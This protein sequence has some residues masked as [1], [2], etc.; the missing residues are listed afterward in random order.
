MNTTG[1]V[2]IGLAALVVGAVVLLSAGRIQA[3]AINLLG[4][5]HI[6]E[7][8]DLPW[9]GASVRAVL[10]ARRE[11]TFNNGLTARRE[12]GTGRWRTEPLHQTVATAVDFLARSP[13]F[14]T[15]PVS[16]EEAEFYEGNAAGV[17]AGVYPVRVAPYQFHL[18]SIRPTVV[19][20]RADSAIV[21]MAQSHARQPEAQSEF[22]RW[23]QEL[24]Y[25]QYLSAWQLRNPIHFGTQL[26]AGDAWQWFSPDLQQ[27]PTPLL[28]D[29]RAI[30]TIPLPDGVLTFDVTE[31]GYTVQRR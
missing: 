25:L 28:L 1:I 17:P 26:P 7:E 12:W 14:T 16:G 22:S 5:T 29:D 19:L 4:G 3:G 2:G 23:M 30:A 20:M 18:V 9:A 27:L 15:W 6:E 8:R 13:E 21:E 31:H 24:D 10:R 11:Y